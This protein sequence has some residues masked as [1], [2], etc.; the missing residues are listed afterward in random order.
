[1]SDPLP[2]MFTIGAK[3]TGKDGGS[4]FLKNAVV[5][6]DYRGPT[7]FKFAGGFFGANQWRIGHFD[8]TNWVTDDSFGVSIAVGI[9][10]DM[11]LQVDG[12][13]ATLSVGGVQKAVANFGVPLNTGEIGLGSHNAVAV[14]DEFAVQELPG[15][16][17]ASTGRLDAGTAT[18]LVDVLAQAAAIHQEYRPGTGAV[19]GRRPLS[20]LGKLLKSDAE[21]NRLFVLLE[22]SE[23]PMD[24][25]I[26]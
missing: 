12:T 6:F 19:W 17:A 9:D 14:F 26:L 22:R 20:P 1:M 15:S 16:L 2:P 5:V 18:P 7:D 23:G 8:G 3:L 24:A 10:Y 4:G 13:T 21:E 11:E 25:G